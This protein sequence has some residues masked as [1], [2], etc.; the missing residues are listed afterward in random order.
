MI[1]TFG[2]FQSRKVGHGNIYRAILTVLM[3]NSISSVIGERNVHLLV[4]LT[5][6]WQSQISEH[7]IDAAYCSF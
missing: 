7:L 1:D 5:F 4:V 6:L 3:M 2:K